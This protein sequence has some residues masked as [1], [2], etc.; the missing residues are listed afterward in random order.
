MPTTFQVQ[1]CTGKSALRSQPTLTGGRGT[2]PHT[3]RPSYQHSV[4]SSLSH[5]FVD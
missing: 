1:I 3:V 5:W 4:S 2:W